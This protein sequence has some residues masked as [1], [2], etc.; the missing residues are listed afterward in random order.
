[1]ICVGLSVGLKSDI[2]GNASFCWLSWKEGTVWAIQSP[3]LIIPLVDLFLIVISWVKILQHQPVVNIPDPLSSERGNQ[4]G[5]ARNNE[6]G[7][8]PHSP[9]KVP[10]KTIKQSKRP[11]HR[12]TVTWFFTISIWYLAWTSINKNNLISYMT[13]CL[14]SISYSII[15]VLYVY[16][17]P[18]VKKAWKLERSR[19][20]RKKNFNSTTAALLTHAVAYYSNSSPENTNSVP[21]SAHTGNNNSRLLE[22]PTKSS[23]YEYRIDPVTGKK[24]KYRV[25]RKDNNNTITNTITSTKDD[26]S[27]ISNSNSKQLSDHGHG[28]GNES[29]KSKTQSLRNNSGNCLTSSYDTARSQQHG[30]Y[31]KK[32]HRSRTPVSSY[33]SKLEE[34][35]LKSHNQPIPEQST[36][37]SIDFRNFKDAQDLYDINPASS[38]T[39]DT[40]ASDIRE[41][42]GLDGRR[43]IKKLKEINRRIG[44]GES[45]PEKSNSKISW[46]D[47]RTI[48]GEDISRKG[49]VVLDSTLRWFL[50]ILT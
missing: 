47:S 19:K 6:T 28:S 1:M 23:I 24:L 4:N 9:L 25:K 12:A 43:E 46:G 45:L 34:L 21:G 38:V 42:E 10:I 48:L 7:S 44:I 13:I 18:E 39:S 49:R 50:N 26:N 14:L 33:S 3:N 20:E 37:D 15:D 35:P 5:N 8:G 32:K 2:F 29:V 16:F 41:Y 31:H 36:L 27:E 40:E 11:L 17:D 30:S 22:T